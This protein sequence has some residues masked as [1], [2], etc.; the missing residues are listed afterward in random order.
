MLQTLREKAQ[1]IVTWVVVLAI[2]A[3]FA[4]FG[5]SDYFSLGGGQGFAAKVNGE[6][7]SWAYIDKYY[8]KVAQ[9]YGSE[10]DPQAL[11]D[12]ILMAMIKRAAWLKAAKA[13]GFRVG[14]EQIAA[15]LVQIPAFQVDGKFSKEQYMKVLAD[16]SYTDASFRQ[17]LSQDVLLGQLEQGLAQSN[18]IMPNEFNSAVALLDQKRDFGY[19]L[20]PAQKYQ[21]DIQI[22]AEKIQSYYEDHKA[23]FIKPEQVSLEY[24]ALD[25]QDLVN[26]I[27]PSKPEILAYYEKHT[28]LYA[29]PERVHARHILVGAPQEDAALEKKAKGKIEGVLVKLK[30]G[31]D[32]AK[33]AKMVSEDPGSAEKGGD[34]GWFMRGQMVPE[35]EKAAFELKAGAI[36]EPVR[37]QFG[38][39]IIQ[40]VE[41]KDAEQ[42]PFVEVQNLV[43]EQVKRERAEAIFAQ[44]SELFAKLA[45]EENSGFASIVE[46]LGLKIK[47]TEP[48][49][50]EGGQGIA[51]NPEVLQAAFSEELLQHGRNST[52][53][54]LSET[55][56]AV[57]RIKKHYPAEQQSLAQVEK[58][59]QQLLALDKA[60]KQI[61]EIGEKAVLEIRNGSSPVQIAKQSKLEWVVKSN[62]QRMASDVD[63]QITMAA[64]QMPD[65]EPKSQ[66]VKGFVL[67]SGDYLVLMLNKIKLGNVA[68]LD[69]QTQQS[70]RQGLTDVSSQLEYALYVNQA[71]RDAKIEILKKPS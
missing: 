31:E 9:Q 28:A 17:E 27:K 62:I 61:K 6:K 5:L 30:K 51:N 19:M 54:K 39:H 70:Y 1:G 64:F 71:L 53:I 15:L 18:F 32:F 55:A 13:L 50:R 3:A 35:F 7:I 56:T 38:Y 24:V 44:Q 58:K 68:K 12:Q 20:I 10:V 46:Q 52:P 57:V 65:S 34:L 43:E 4:F 33:L 11:K 48:F 14:D 49:S 37:T 67:P 2:A 59:I 63:R 66:N 41:H 36:S 8:E 16:A 22:S 29:L 60:K 40:L 23:S 25:F 42:R 45:F 47:Q 69:A 21:Q 26:S